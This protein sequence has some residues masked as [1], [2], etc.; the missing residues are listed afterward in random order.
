MKSFWKRYSYSV[1]KLFVNQFAISIFGLVL[2]LACGKAENIT[3]MYVTSIGAII[4]YLFLLYAALW[5]IGAKDKILVDGGRLPKNNL[6]GLYMG[7][8]ANIPNFILAILVSIGL[9]FADG[10]VISKIGGVASSIS[11]FIQGMYSGI[12]AIDVGG[13]PLNTYFFVYFLIPLPAI[14]ICTLSYFFGI[15]NYHFT[16]LLISETPDE[17]EIRRE[18]K[19]RNK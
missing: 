11:I 1:I 4:F 13:A 19:K 10:G 15:K 7:L 9:L 18:K 2:A 12:L 16:K 14:L 3:L 6:N 8:L 5:E 17:A